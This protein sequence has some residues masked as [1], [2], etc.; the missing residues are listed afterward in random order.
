VGKVSLPLLAGFQVLTGNIGVAIA[1]RG[2]RGLTQFHPG[3]FGG[4]TGLTPVAGYAGADQ[5]F[6][7]VRSTPISRDNMVQGKLPS[8]FATVLTRIVITGEN[9]ESTQLSSGTEG[10]FDQIGKP[11]DRRYLDILVRPVNKSSAVLQHFGLALVEQHHCPA[12][13]TDVQRLV[14]LIQHQYGK[15]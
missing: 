8:L 15:I 6:P 14:V 12:S 9:L 7:G 4:L 13:P 1:A 3:F 2:N 10:A 11:D 5:V